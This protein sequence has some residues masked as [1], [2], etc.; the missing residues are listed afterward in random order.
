MNPSKKL[1]ARKLVRLRIY[2]AKGIEYQHLFERVMQYHDRN[3]TPVK[4][5]G[6][7]GDRK[8]DGYNRHSGQYFQVYAPENPAAVDAPHKAA[9]KA[10]NDFAGLRVHWQGSCP[11]REY[12]FAFND[13]FLGSPPP[14]EDALSKIRT[15]HG[16]DAGV[17]LAKDLEDI[18][19]GLPE[20]QMADILGMVVPD[21]GILDNVD[22]GVLGDVIRHVRRQRAPLQPNGLLKSLEFEA[23]LKFN[24]LS[25]ELAGLLR[26]G[27]YQNEAVTDFFSKN[28]DFARQHLRDHLSAMYVEIRAIHAANAQ[29][30][31]YVG[32]LVFVELWHRMT[33]PIPKERSTD[34]L[35]AQEAAL[36]VM[37]YY[38]EACDVFESPD[39]TT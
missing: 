36:V 25:V 14:L 11:I 1:I 39:A 19:L 2:E 38:F 13:H 4:P 22:F 27:A 35:A 6:N 10:A 5:H 9:Q 29:A 17:L 3:F 8:N 20:D 15:D 37:A 18:V 12:R 21:A 7:V 23:K 28:S 26:V 24:G 31:T 32:D 34:A 16:I 33:P 30:A